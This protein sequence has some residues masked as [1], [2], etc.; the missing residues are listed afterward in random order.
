MLIIFLKGKRETGPL[1][2]FVIVESIRLVGFP[3]PDTF[4][5][6]ERDSEEELTSFWFGLDFAM[7]SFF[8]LVV[9]RRIQ[10]TLDYRLSQES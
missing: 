9:Y 3:L 6:D 1:Y 8:R 7:L 4:V 2:P 5:S 10:A